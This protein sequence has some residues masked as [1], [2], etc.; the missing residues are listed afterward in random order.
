[1]TSK[2][3]AKYCVHILRQT[4]VLHHLCHSP[5]RSQKTLYMQGLSAN[6]EEVK[7][8]TIYY[9]ESLHTV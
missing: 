4:Q 6:M 2:T 8:Y 1:M 7:V 3:I 9:F 5:L